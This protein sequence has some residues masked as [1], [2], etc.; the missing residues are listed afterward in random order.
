MVCTFFGDRDAPDS[1]EISL[2]STLVHLVEDEKVTLFYVGNHG[3]F[4]NLILRNLKR[5]KTHYAQIRYYVV[6][7]YMPGDKQEY[8]DF[9]DSIYPGG[10]ES[11]PQRYAIIKRNEWMIR[12]A[13]YVVTYA[14][15][16]FKNALKFKELAKR[17]IVSSLN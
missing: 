9:S 14:K 4:D 13:D 16:P 7:A 17:K 15:N 6:L 12:R 2:Y 3:R 8:G 11:I 5:L 10:L 1:I